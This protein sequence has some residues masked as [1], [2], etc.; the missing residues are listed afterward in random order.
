MGL[1][2]FNCNTQS[3]SY[4]YWLRWLLSYILTWI[5]F[6]F[7][8]FYPQKLYTGTLDLQVSDATTDQQM[9]CAYLIEK[10]IYQY[11]PKNPS[12]GQPSRH[13]AYYLFF[14]ILILYCYSITVV[15]L[16]SPSLHPTPAE[17]TSRPNLHPPPWFCPCVLILVPVIPSPHCPLPT[18]PCP[19]LD[20]S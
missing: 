2:I 18:P 10:V 5:Y 9:L 8:M 15:C 12:K 11:L 16:F 20:C 14:L 6:N 17:P 3:L 7:I 13:L 1:I 4:R 19:L